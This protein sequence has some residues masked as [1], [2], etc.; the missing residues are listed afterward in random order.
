MPLLGIDQLSVSKTNF[1]RVVKG[2]CRGV[3]LGK[4][5]YHKKKSR[6]TIALTREQNREERERLV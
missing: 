5:I 6:P 1:V 2:K 4:S 3:A